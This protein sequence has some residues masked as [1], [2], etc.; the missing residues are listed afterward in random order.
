[1]NKLIWLPILTFLK[2]LLQINKDPFVTIEIFYFIGHDLRHFLFYFRS[3][4]NTYFMDKN[5]IKNSR[6][7]KMD[8]KK[9]SNCNISKYLS[10]SRGLL[11]KCFVVLGKLKS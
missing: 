11:V 7:S 4:Y 1:M 3:I 8:P 2:I 5:G 10:G 6:S 9:S